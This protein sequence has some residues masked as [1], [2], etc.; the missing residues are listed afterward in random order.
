MNDKLP[1]MLAVAMAAVGLL[2]FVLTHEDGSVQAVEQS[3][4][5]PQYRFEDHLTVIEFELDDGT[6]CIMVATRSPG[7]VRLAGP[8][9]P[10]QGGISCN[11]N[12]TE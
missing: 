9:I 1:L 8:G 6:P 11:W 2:A 5:A 10:G 3:E 12:H 4:T 7:R